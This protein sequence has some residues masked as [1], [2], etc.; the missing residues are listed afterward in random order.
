M[1]MCRVKPVAGLGSSDKVSGGCRRRLRLAGLPFDRR[2]QRIPS[3]RYSG[4]SLGLPG[5][6][7]RR[8]LVAQLVRAHA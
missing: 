3:P 8:G 4:L 6:R 2:R 5:D 1:Q 7:G